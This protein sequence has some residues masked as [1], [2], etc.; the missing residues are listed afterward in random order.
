[1]MG[2]VPVP[3]HA[4][5]PLVGRD[6][7]VRQLVELVGLA[8]PDRAAVVLLAGEAGVGKTRLLGELTARAESA[9]WR[10]LTGHCLDF[11]D[12]ALPYLPFTEIVGRLAQTAP[13]V[14][15][16]LT[17]R[18]AALQHLLPGRRLL[19]G[20]GGAD[21]E[22]MDRAVLF[23]AV[24]LA[25]EELAVGAPLLVVLEDLHWADQ[26]TRDLLTFLFMRGFDGPVSLVATYR[27]DDMHRRHPLRA[28]L[29]QWSRTSRVQRLQLAPLS[30][31][32][33]RTLVRSLRTGPIPE[34]DLHAIVER[35]EGNAFFAEELVAAELGGSGLPEDL[36][37][38][39]LVRLD[40]LDE[41]ARLVVRAASC[42]G[43]QVSHALLAAV[44]DLD[45]P[46]L[47]R[48]VRAAVDS[49]VLVPV[50]TS[51]A[52]RHALLAEAVHDDLLPGERVRLHAAYVTALVSH[53][54]EGTAAELARHARAAHDVP[55]AVTAS[56][57]A[58]DD[59]MAVG[60]PDD[61][62]RHYTLALE[63]L[64]GPAGRGEADVSVDVVSLTARASDA[65]LAAGDPPRA[66]ELVQ[67]QIAQLPAD[68]SRTDRARLL[69]TL[70]MAALMGDTTVNAL[71]ATTEALALAGSE[72]TPLRAKAMS[73]HARANA[74][75]QRSDEA[76][77][78]AAEAMV[79]GEQLG[80]RRVVADAATTMAR[81]DENAGR[82][83]ESRRTF[84]KIVA[85]A[86]SDGDVVT[87][88][89]GLHH[90][91]ALLFEAGQLDGAAEVYA[92]AAARSVEIGRPWAPYGFD[93]RVMLGI[94]TYVAGRWDETLQI[95][96][97]TGEA[98][99]EIAEGA[100]S[101]VALGVAAGRG[102]TSALERFPAVRAVW[103]KDGLVA[104]LSG[105]AAIDL[106]GDAGDLSAAVEVHDAVVESVRG[107]WQ[108]D[109]FMAQIRLGA[110][111]LGQLAR[112]VPAVGSDERRALGRRGDDLLAVAR[113][114]E[115]RATSRGQQIGPEGVAWRERAAAEHRRL[116][117]LAGIDTPSPDELLAGWQ[118]TVEAFA[119]FG[120]VL[121]LARSRARLSVVLRSLGRVDEARAEVDLAR[122]AGQ[123]LG[124]DP[125]L[126]ELRV[127]GAP[128]PRREAVGRD[129]TLTPREL[130]ILVLVAQGRTN[131]EI[132]KQLFISAKT[133]SVHVSNILAKLGASGRTE[134][135]ALARTRGL[136]PV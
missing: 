13:E 134:A 119:T 114:A 48:A 37:G 80:L 136:L 108:V 125:L 38:L 112:H 32:A 69:M 87:E 86:R 102:D 33:V 56:I 132:A 53:A 26:S 126:I 113:L 23:D 30:D 9:G 34:R 65:L 120:H 101:A 55:V 131:G 44:V 54:A 27:S 122:A 115:E 3:H 5:T 18:H 59:A 4:Q 76:M 82:P 16:D 62:A 15:A 57:E 128:R 61:A 81:L 94:T 103:E 91:G 135:A 107:V 75:R 84:E 40:Q 88:L 90:L 100:L 118:R 127:S 10:T 21:A 1:M 60:G 99:P 35:A 133:V 52:F 66:L 50:G 116:R 117:W 83:E 73:V 19:S 89:R 130:E 11:G 20:A 25:L 42:A 111:L 97:M 71:E 67:D 41:A 36:A 7:D 68:A 14:V 93:A 92:A 51:Y 85:Q 22:S 124:A 6:D 74:D 17:E 77:R 95:T 98:P 129:A 104:I 63:L 24:H 79:L 70:A 109:T 12:S 47:E 72:P 29:A 45:E 46:A 106:H 43:R 31:R 78:W 64:G 121:E 28:S 8:H 105:A 96:D 123:R 58:G 110:L 2:D 39:L 49:N